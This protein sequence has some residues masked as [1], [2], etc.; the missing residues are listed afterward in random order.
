MEEDIFGYGGTGNQEIDDTN[1]PANGEEKTDLNSGKVIVDPNGEP[2]DDLDNQKPPVE[3]ND[4]NKGETDKDDDKFAVEPGTEIE[5]GDDK[6]TVDEN[7]NVVDADGNI[8]KEA[9]DVAE[10]IKTFDKVDETDKSKDM[11]IEN[12]IKT[13][14]VEILDDNDKPIE[15]DNTPEG[16]KAYIK[17]VIETSKQEVAEAA[18]NTLFSKY[19]ILPEVINYYVANGGSLKGFDEIPDSNVICR[20][21]FPVSPTPVMR[22]V[23]RAVNIG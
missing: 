2:A 1:P 20:R 16:V 10:W 9:K 19:P 22:I 3:E 7:G 4:T 12:I 11:S 8:F 15:Y 17:D 5:V 6:Y 13:M 14:D 21:S 18:V 23:L